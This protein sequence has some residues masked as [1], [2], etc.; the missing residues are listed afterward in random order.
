[1]PR[2]RRRSRT[3]AVWLSVVLGDLL[4]ARAALADCPA[5]GGVLSYI[6]EGWNTL[7]RSSHS[8][9]TSAQDL[10]VPGTGHA[11]IWVAPDEDRNAVEKAIRGPRSHGNSRGLAV[12]QLSEEQ[13][14]GRA[15]S[16]QEPGL[17]YLPKPYVVPGGRFNEMHGWDSYFITLGLLRDHRTALAKD[18]TDNLLY[19]VRHYGKVLNGNRTYFLTRSHPPFLSRMVLDVF[20]ET[21]DI[22]WLRRTLP[23]LEKYYSY[24]TSEPHLTPQTGL[25]RYWGGSD[26]PSPEVVFSERDDS[27]K[28]EYER[29]IEYYRSHDVK[30]YDIKRYYDSA[31][32]TLTPLFYEADRA[33]RESGFDPS[34]RFGPFSAAIVDYNTV[35]LNAL[36][37]RMETDLATVYSL[38]DEPR[39]SQ[40]W[41]ERAQ[42]RR[43][44]VE[45]LMWDEEAGFFF[46]YDFVNN[47]RS[48]YLYLT[49]FFPLWAGLATRKQAAV[50]VASLPVF[51][52]VGGLQASANN[53]GSQWDAPFGWAPLH[54]IAIEGLRR[55]GF[56]ESAE[57]I[58]A[59]FLAMIT[60]DFAKHHTLMEK[61]DVAQEKSDVG[62]EIEFGYTTNE[63]GFGWTNAV[64]LLL[65]EELSAGGRQSLAGMCPR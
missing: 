46:D 25:S 56:D 63:V 9:M 4:A 5:L 45:R 22:A 7:T 12:K 59:K 57:R 61:Y 15:Q 17:L 24:W 31:T 33:M 18:M 42:A 62:R 28:N 40:T 60:G 44:A 29:I 10:K 3:L 32:G 30:E 2:L 19:E 6:H 54:L 27:G 14:S 11:I 1:M 38:L 47:R 35:A 52:R 65:Y 8:A 39:I 50:M 48:S 13:L 53:S 58:S 21:G 55:Y 43:E 23:D 26:Q 51:E 36:L 64:F 49:T 16:S 20:R 41:T 37:Y 34:F